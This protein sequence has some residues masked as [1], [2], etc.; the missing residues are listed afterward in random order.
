MKNKTKYFVILLILNILTIVNVKSDE[1]FKFDVT[2]IEIIDNGN[3]I[4]GYKGGTATADNG[5]KIKAESFEY[6]KVLNILN[7]F[8]NVKIIDEINNYIIFS[9]KITYIKDQEKIF[10]QGKT[11]AILESRY[12]FLSKNVL[13]LK[14]EMILSSNE[15]SSLK[16]ED[17]YLYKF[18]KFNYSFY[19]GILKA[20]KIEIISD[21]QKS[22]DKKDYYFFDD[23]IIDI[24]NKNFTAGNTKI[25]IKKDSFENSKND[26]RIYGVSS[27]K[28]GKV[29]TIKK[30]VFTSCALN[31]DCPPWSI[32]SSEILHDSEKKQIIYKNAFLKIYDL[33][34]LYFPKFFHPD[35]S[36]ER[37]SGF[38]QPQLNNSNILG[39]SFRIPYF[40]VL[41]ENKDLTFTP[42][43]FDKDI[44]MMQN[45]YRQ[46]NKN[47][48]LIADI[49]FAKGY[50]S[51]VTDNKKKNIGHLFAKFDLNL[52]LETFINSD[53]KVSLENVTNDTYLKVF[54]SNLTNTNPTIMPKNKGQLTSNIELNLD[55]EN[56]SF[57]TGITA[58]ETL[59]GTDSDRYQYVLPY[60]TFSKNLISNQLLSLNFNSDGNNN[61][62]NTNNLKT[63]INNNFDFKSID[64]ISENGFKNNIGFHFK[65]VNTVAKNDSK[66]KSSPQLELMNI[67]NLET[68]LP[69]IKINDEY[70]NS[71]IPKISFRYNP[72]DM[73]D[74][75]ES[76]RY[77]DANNIFS[78]NRLAISDSYESGQS[79]TIGVDY[80]KET[81]KDINKFFE[82]NLA[83]VLRDV[84]QDTIPTK[85]TLGEKQS[86]LFGKANY[87]LSKMVSLNYDFALDNDLQTFEHNSIG[88]VFNF[89]KLTS[90][91][92]F[93][94]TTGKMGDTNFIT[95]TTKFTINEDNF[96]S[97]NTRR[98]RKISLTEYYNLVYEY[99][100]DCLV[101]GVKYKKTYYQDRD[102]IPAEDLLFSI[103]LFP[104]TTYETKVDQDL[105]RE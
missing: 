90:S 22:K 42:S 7:A 52:D 15:K 72:T 37:Q 99:K 101:A 84:K 45:E 51:V 104:L 19:D 67:I 103:T 24:K 40:H 59:S 88:T 31:D 105:Y 11:E 2:E 61:Y 96:L 32:N 68:S 71:I 77:I 78:L 49:G 62:Q 30:G 8:G 57:D 41:D 28:R 18:E 94:E 9:E 21:Y 91:F 5:L 79:L 98:N 12:N 3:T 16:D 86:N 10:T 66:Y 33:P 69:L 76:D 47:S 95:N 29:T 93:V 75:S 83:T 58:Y 89:D 46:E 74:Y 56:F 43:V 13:L 64:F 50:K 48:S 39:S 81:I 35:P 92:D 4:K 70:S 100:N 26:P 73:K 17:V 65:N 63:V 23:G 60:Y 44:Y 1:Q 82:F 14:N 87:G 38:L 55:H 53:L 102:L 97:F 54:D 6:D 36:V 80:K 25:K 34:V 20:K 85:S 27:K